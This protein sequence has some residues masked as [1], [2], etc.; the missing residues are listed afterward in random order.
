VDF[1]ELFALLAPVEFRHF[2]QSHDWSSAAEDF[3]NG[4]HRIACD[5]HIGSILQSNS[6]DVAL[7]EET[8]E[9]AGKCIWFDSASFRTLYAAGSLT[10]MTDEAAAAFVHSQRALLDA[11]IWQETSVHLQTPLQLCAIALAHGQTTVAR[12]LCRQTWELTTGYAHR[13]D[14]TLNN[15]VDAIG[16]LVDVVPDEAR[17]LLGQVAPQIHQVL[18]YTD[19][20]GTRHVLAAADEL[21]AKLRPSALVVKYEEHTHAGDW[22][23]AE[24]SLRAY[25]EQGVKDNWPLDALMRSGLHPEI[26]DV[27]QRLAQDGSTSAVDRFRVLQEHNGWG[28]GV[29][30]RQ[31]H[32]GSSIESKPYDGD[33]TAFKPEQL[34]DLLE[35]LSTS[36]KERTKLLRVWYQYWVM[37]GQGRRLLDALDG[38]L[39]SKEGRQKDVLS[40]YDLAFQTRRKLS[41][42]NAA[43]KYLVHAQIQSGAW[44]GFAE[45]D[46]KTRAR[47]Y[48]VAQHYPR[49]CD[50]FVAETTYGM[51]GNPELPRIAPTNLM[52]YFYVLQG[53]IAEAVGFAETMVNCVIEDTRTLPLV[54]PSWA[55]ELTSLTVSET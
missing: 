14:P 11:E 31:E 1:H 21:L 6:D 15:T 16:Y 30:Q 10:R 3:R 17:R 46:K 50:E 42:A 9:A 26:C 5:I 2:R 19:G 51:F 29:L 33:V 49:R 48:L 34:H 27:L 35:S 41:G 28:V 18:Q 54:L 39:L 8:M 7:T 52:V 37:E 23:L 36:Y 44:T 22:S 13:K 40:L 55:A 24:N 45:S 53:R 4:L 43:W 25:V 12:E 47:L 32:A 20:K 38:L